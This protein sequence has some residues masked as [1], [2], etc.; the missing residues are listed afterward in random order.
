MPGGEVTEKGFQS[1]ILD[2]ARL[3][4]WRVYHTHDSRR[5][6]PGFPDL[7]MVRPPVV[8]FAE[9]K[10]ESGVV[11]PEQREWLGALRGCEDV[12]AKLWRPSSWP[13]IEEVLTRR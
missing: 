8:L 6:A 4:G 11:R 10:S 5:S 3:C 1:Q 9:L 13:E 12:K 2:L 7:V